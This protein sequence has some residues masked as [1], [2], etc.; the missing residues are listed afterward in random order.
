[1]LCIKLCIVRCINPAL[2]F[3]MSGCLIEPIWLVFVEFSSSGSVE[4][5]G[6]LLHKLSN[7]DDD[8]LEEKRTRRNGL[9]RVWTIFQVARH[10]SAIDYA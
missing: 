3:L 1:M 8:N 10:R 9:Q 6:H 7:A 2:E 4:T 5:S